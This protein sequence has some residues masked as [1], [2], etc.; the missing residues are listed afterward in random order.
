MT[1]LMWRSLAT[2]LSAATA[3][4]I[5]RFLG[6]EDRG[7]L[8]MLLLYLSL[9]ALLFQFGMPEALIYLIGSRKYLEQKILGSSLVLVAITSIFIMPTSYWALTEY[10]KSSFSILFELVIA[11][12]FLITATYGRHLLLGMRRF[13]D[14]SKS[15]IVESSSY[16]MGAIALW[17]FEKLTIPNVL[18][19]YAISLVLSA[20][21]AW[22]FVFKRMAVKPIIDQGSSAIIY[23]CVQRGAHLFFTGLGGFGTQRLCYFFLELYIGSSSVGLYA[24]ACAIPGLI[25]NGAQQISTVLYSHISARKSDSNGLTL[26][27]AVF[28]IQM[29]MGLIMLIPIAI[30]SDEIVRLLFGQAYVGIGNTV[31]ILS[32]AM[33]IAGLSSSLLNSLAGMGMHKIGSLYTTLVL[34]TVAAFSFIF[35]PLYGLVGAAIS[36]F[37]A[38]A[39]GLVLT[40][41]IYRYNQKIKF[42]CFFQIPWS[43]WISTVSK[44]LR[45][46]DES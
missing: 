32:F 45:N 38:N 41:V 26:T 5:A 36:Q 22:T 21:V 35:I 2:F 17:A 10:S 27:L 13:S 34:S 31:T 28:H 40:L 24:A 4:L 9:F 3:V 7:V 44:S 1:M 20:I 23:D 18:G 12:I 29:I 46:N 15:L 8:A 43:A 39:F 19:A 42:Q 30:F 37:L 14:Y 6:P 25:S 16:L 11:G 33:L